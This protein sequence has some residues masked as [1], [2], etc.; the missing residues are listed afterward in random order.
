MLVDGLLIDDPIKDYVAVGVPGKSS[1][2]GL[3]AVWIA[4]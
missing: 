2:S 1:H 4:R 3:G